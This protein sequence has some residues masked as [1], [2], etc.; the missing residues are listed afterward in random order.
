[1]IFEFFLFSDNGI[2]NQ[3]E[4][5]KVS[6]GPIRLHKS[7]LIAKKGTFNKWIIFFTLTFENI[8]QQNV[9]RIHCSF[10]LFC[11]KH[12]SLPTE[13]LKIILLK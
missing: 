10:G 3:P 1:M 13:E 6:M 8:S 5:N 11:L 7:V 4:V 9:Q 12:E 2:L